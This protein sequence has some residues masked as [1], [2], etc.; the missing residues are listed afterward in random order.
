[1]EKEMHNLYLDFTLTLQGFL[2][3]FHSEKSPK[4]Y[5]ILAGVQW[6]QQV[7]PPMLS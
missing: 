5:V 7:L 6:L 1:M 2:L 4:R 3:V